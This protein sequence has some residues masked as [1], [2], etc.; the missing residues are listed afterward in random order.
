MAMSIQF[1]R[2]EKSTSLQT[3]KEHTIMIASHGHAMHE[4]SETD[5]CSKFLFQFSAMPEINV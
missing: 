4:S 1:A 5:G 2:I 3:G